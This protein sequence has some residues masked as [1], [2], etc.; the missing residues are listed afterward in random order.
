MKFLHSSILAK[1]SAIIVLASLISLSITMWIEFQ[2]SQSLA[3]SHALISHDIDYKRR[4]MQLHTDYKTQVQEWK[5]V[6][7]RGHEPEQLQ[8][9]WGRFKAYEQHIISEIDQLRPLLSDEP[10]SN[11][12]TA[13]KEEYLATMPIYQQALGVFKQGYSARE[14]DSV[15]KGIDRESSQLL[16]EVGERI[17]RYADNR[18]TAVINDSKFIRQFSLP[19]TIASQLVILLII[20]YVIKLQLVNP[21][22][23]LSDNIKV[24]SSKD[25]TATIEVNRSDEIGKIADDIRKLS[26]S[27][28]EMFG[29]FSSLSRLINNASHDISSAS[30]EIVADTHS[31]QDKTRNAVTAIGQMSASIHEVANN[32]ANAAV[33]ANEANVAMSNGLQLTNEA[34]DAAV[35]LSRQVQRTAEVIQD[36][37][38]KT[39]SVS[40]VVDVISSIADQTNLLALNAAIEAARAGEFGRGFSVVADEVRTLAFRTQEST[41]EIKRIIEETQQSAQKANEVMEKGVAQ[42]DHTAGL[43]QEVA[44]SINKTAS[45]V[46]EIN[47]LNM[48]MAAAAEQQ[49]RVSEDININMSQVYESASS[50]TEKADLTK[51]LALNLDSIAST[52]EKMV[53]E[54]KFDDE[55]NAVEL[56]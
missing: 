16:F 33:S 23:E 34:T 44:K 47:A 35:N 30:S 52:L 27:I 11:G 19:I 36:L 21:T 25:L 38:D 41:E 46:G 15:V 48:Q 12:L 28:K 45:M 24:L 3:Q 9:Y 2:L 29:E 53:S 13:F 49:S 20:I 1:L 50:T 7:L 40:T 18:S 56:F 14:A 31:V 51:E 22:R 43:S 8:K 6:L 5:N 4:V 17:K 39:D 42:T 54:Y 26:L 10:A 55:K 37:V 32:A